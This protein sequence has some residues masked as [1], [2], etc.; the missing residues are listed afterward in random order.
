MCA[1]SGHPRG[2]REIHKRTDV[3]LIQQDSVPVGDI[4][5]PIQEGTQHAH[6]LSTFHSDLVDGRRKGQT[7]I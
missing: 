2:A 1:G 4:T 6:S 7:P 5:V 3:Q